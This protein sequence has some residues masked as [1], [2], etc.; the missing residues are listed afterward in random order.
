MRRLF[1]R[2]IAAMLL[3]MAESDSVV[4][5]P[6]ALYAHGGSSCG[7]FIENKGALCDFEQMSPA[8]SGAIWSGTMLHNFA[9]AP[10]RRSRLGRLIADKPTEGALSLNKEAEGLV[11]RTGEPVLFRF[12]SPPGSS[13][14]YQVYLA[15]A[16]YYAGMD[17]LI[18]ITRSDLNELVASCGPFNK[19]RPS[20]VFLAQP[21]TDYTIAITDRTEPL[22]T[23][24]SNGRFILMITPPLYS[25]PEISIGRGVLTHVPGRGELPQRF[26]FKFPGDAPRD[27]SV[28]LSNIPQGIQLRVAIL[29]EQEQI[30]N[31]CTFS[32]SSSPQVCPFPSQPGAVRFITVSNV[33]QNTSGEAY[34]ISIAYT[35]K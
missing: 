19:A 29:E 26:I 23:S 5:A 11:L 34:S 4:A 30:L 27:Y 20:C 18:T 14:P 15:A 7:D 33:S 22:F 3:A 1:P 21:E 8:T 35:I 32:R 10:D 6:I 16:R 31:S 9:G 2:L 13:R 24:V 17:P 25:T 12:H 28:Q